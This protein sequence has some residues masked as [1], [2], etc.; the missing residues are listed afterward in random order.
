MTSSLRIAVSAALAVLLL[1]ACDGGLDGGGSATM[2]GTFD[3]VSVSSDAEGAS[4]TASAVLQ[5]DDILD[6]EIRLRLPDDAYGATLVIDN[7]AAEMAGRTIAVGSDEGV[8]GTVSHEGESA[9]AATGT[10]RFDILEPFPGGAVA[11]TYDLDFAGGNLAGEFDAV[12]E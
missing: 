8:T 4:A 10:V 1:A 12:V 6:V 2:S 11:G 7:P 3:G 9:R 5:G